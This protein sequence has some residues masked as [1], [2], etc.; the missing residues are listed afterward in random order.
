MSASPF[1]RTFFSISYVRVKP[2]SAT[3]ASCVATMDEMRSPTL[4]T[5]SLMGVDLFSKR[6]SESSALTKR[7]KR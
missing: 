5:S 6:E 2:E 3:N 4:T 1:T 7:P